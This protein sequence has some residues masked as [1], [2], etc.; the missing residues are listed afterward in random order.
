M[1]ITTEQVAD[2]RPGDVVEHRD[3]RHPDVVTRGPLCALTHGKG[4]RL[5]RDILI[6]YPDG[7]P[8][9][10]SHKEL[11]LIERKPRPLYVNHDRMEP[12]IGD[13]VRSADDETDARVWGCLDD[14]DMPWKLIGLSRGWLTR[15]ELP[16]RLRLLVDGSTGL[17]AP[18]EYEK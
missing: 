4:L 2:L 13:V 6:R 14:D 18:E 7:S 16:K 8:A 5:G 15:E 10:D 11:M 1:T 3:T 9:I 17:P 12:R